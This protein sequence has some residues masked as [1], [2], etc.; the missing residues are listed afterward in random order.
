MSAKRRT[1]RRLKTAVVNLGRRREASPEIDDL[2]SSDIVRCPAADNVIRESADAEKP[3]TNFLRLPS[4]YRPDD[5]NTLKLPVTDDNALK[6]PVI[7]DDTLKVPVN[8]DTGP[9]LP[10]NDNNT[11]ESPING[12]TAIQ[13][14]VSDYNTSKSPGNTDATQTLPI[15]NFNT[16]KLPVSDD[17]VIQLPVKDDN[18]IKSPVNEGTVPPLPVNDDNIF[19]SP[20]NEGTASQLPVNDDNIFKSPGNEGTAPPLPV[21]DD[22]IFKSPDNKNNVI[23]L[24]FNDDNA[25]KLHVNNDNTFKLAVN[26]DTALKLPAINDNTLQLSVNVDTP[27]KL[28]VDD[29]NFPILPISTVKS[30]ARYENNL[31]LHVNDDNNS[32]QLNGHLHVYDDVTIKPHIHDDNTLIVYDEVDNAITLPVNDDN[33]KTLHVR[34]DNTLNVPVNDDA[35]IILHVYDDNT[36][37]LHDHDYD[38]SFNMLNVSGDDD[39]PLQLLSTKDK[40]TLK[41]PVCDDNMVKSP[42]PGGDNALK[43]PV[44]ED[45]NFNVSVT[46]DN[47]LGLPVND[48]ITLDLP[49][50]EDNTPV[51]YNII[52]DI[53]ADGDNQTIQISDHDIK[54]ND[55]IIQVSQAHT[56]ST[57]VPDIITDAKP[58]KAVKAY[59]RSLPDKNIQKDYFH[60][61]VNNDHAFKTWVDNAQIDCPVN[62]FHHDG[63]FDFATENGWLPFLSEGYCQEVEVV[64]TDRYSSN[65]FELLSDNAAETQ[66]NSSKINLT[67]DTND[68]NASS[69][70]EW[71][72]ETDKSDSNESLVSVTASPRKRL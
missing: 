6:L 48:N 27:F 36:I 7:D 13:L 35:T 2:F 19:K 38:N 58:T 72:P 63:D 34:D 32:N 5:D 59:D 9:T 3:D 51:D 26:D 37:K 33:T 4:R 20:G 69:E 49:V 29:D 10:V 56:D 17:T 18:I 61:P 12:D 64:H 25:K 66:Q 55:V 46:G 31:E 11:F 47:T 16:I 23:H 45:P 53:V 52:H 50:C 41:L 67:E 39:K 15:N 71:M 40:N 21:N 60:V 62:P 42:I 68:K 24:H 70:D 65:E 57:H 44:I 43:L 30:H 8:N 54:V 28:P 1:R 22:N 14:P